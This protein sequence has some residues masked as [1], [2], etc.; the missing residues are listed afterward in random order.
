MMGSG[1]IEM[2]KEPRGSS[3]GSLSELGDGG[4]TQVIPR[5]GG[6]YI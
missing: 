5:A 4:L 2:K 6:H 3:G 1:G